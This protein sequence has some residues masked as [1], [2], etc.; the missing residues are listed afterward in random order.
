MKY[1]LPLILLFLS[2]SPTGAK[3]KEKTTFTAIEAAIVAK[4]AYLCGFIDGSRKALVDTFGVNLT[5]LDELRA[6][7]S[8]TLVTELVAT[9]P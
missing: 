5:A 1:F 6:K 9:L 2:A 4:T 3:R 7:T 8:C